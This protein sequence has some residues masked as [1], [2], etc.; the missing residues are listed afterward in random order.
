MN[1]IASLR[2]SLGSARSIHS[3]R[4]SDRT[5]HRPP[6]HPHRL[7]DALEPRTLLYTPS[8]IINTAED[9]FA[10]LI[11]TI[12]AQNGGEVAGFGRTVVNVGDINADGAD[13]LA[14][15]APGGGSAVGLVQL[16]SGK[17]GTLLWT[18]AGSDIG[19]GRAIT[20]I[21]DATSDGV[22]DIAIGS[23]L[24]AVAGAVFIYNG[25]TGAL[26]STILGSTF[27]AISGA[28]FGWSLAAGLFNPDQTQ[29]LAIGAPT[30][31]AIGEG[32]VYIVDGTDPATAFTYAGSRESELFGWSVEFIEEPAPGP[33]FLA[34]GG[35]GWPVANHQLVNLGRISIVNYSGEYKFWVGAANNEM[36]GISLASLPPTE[37]GVRRLAV[38]SPGGNVWLDGELSARRNT[39]IVSIY[40]IDASLAGPRAYITSA[41]TGSR[42]GYSL[43]AGASRIII[44]APGAADN[45]KVYVHNIPA[46]GD[47]YA[48]YVDSTLVRTIRAND[49][50]NF[51]VALAAGEFNLDGFLDVAISSGLSITSIATDP[52]ENSSGRVS[53]FTSVEFS[54]ATGS[55]CLS[56]D[57]SYQVVHPG[58]S[59]SSFLAH[60]GTLTKIDDNF[61]TAGGTFIAIDNTGR[62]LIS[63][64]G[65]AWLFSAGTLTNLSAA[66]TTYVG[67]PDGWA[68]DSVMT[69]RAI[70]ADGSVLVERLRNNSGTTNQLVNRTIW[71]LDAT[72]ATYLWQGEYLAHSAY[73]ALGRRLDSY[74]ADT[75]DRTWTTMLYRVGAGIEEIASIQNAAAITDDGVI[76]GVD[77][78]TNSFV[79]RTTDATLTTLFAVLDA[80]YADTLWPKA[81]DSDGRLLWFQAEDKS[82]YAGEH[83]YWTI[84]TLQIFDPESGTSSDAADGAIPTYRTTFGAST[85]STTVSFT[86]SHGFVVSNPDPYNPVGVHY[87]KAGFDSRLTTPA[88]GAT[89][90]TASGS[91]WTATAFV[92]QL[93]RITLAIDEGDGQWKLRYAA[94]SD[95]FF[96]GDSALIGW[97]DPLTNRP[98]FAG[99]STRF[100]VVHIA[101]FPEVDGLT[102]RKP[103]WLW[104]TR[105]AQLTD[106]DGNSID[107]YSYP[108]FTNNMVVLAR[109][110]NLN[111]LAVQNDFGELYL[112]GQVQNTIHNPFS[113]T[114]LYNLTHELS[115]R[116]N[117]APHFQGAIS[118]FVSPWG[119]H[120]I[121]GVDADGHVWTLWTSPEFVGWQSTDL[122]AWIGAE[123]F[124]GNVTSFI[125]TWNAFNMTGL[126]N[127]GRLTTLWWAPELGP[128]NWEVSFIGEGQTAWDTGVAID[129]WFNQPTQSLNFVGTNESGRVT[130][131]T[132]S[133]SNQTWRAE[134]P[135]NDVTAQPVHRF[136][137]DRYSQ[138]SSRLVGINDADHVIWAYRDPNA[139]ISYDLLMLLE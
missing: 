100:A 7:I 63:R 69:P 45:G 3:L 24:H 61:V 105:P 128:G 79:K 120:N 106:S 14:I 42:F 41:E 80:D 139:W 40:E 13:D 82:K 70:L 130:V 74:N 29:D 49:T 31:G 114:Y 66:I 32:R 101:S 85:I 15:G 102:T 39:G 25:A 62:V 97:V 104:E 71:R 112:I 108:E 78:A 28:R 94:Y 87:F 118:A 36:L 126:D 19:F 23:P 129:S 110:D 107:S 83:W 35:P 119:S 73:G 56:P 135:E 26:V 21:T 111:I 27:N 12:E 138:K 121:T 52:T 89:P 113:F 95:D 122:T 92:N 72:T 18:A 4:N 50:T 81:L 133:V 137:P 67:T 33:Q 34:I 93:G 117:P 84:G 65:A 60:R 37:A 131:Y 43:D 124:A 77:Y 46:P 38:G 91:T 17:T 88:P 53:L 76:V 1:S 75:N 59:D 68:F 99:V 44:G 116:H 96:S 64:S 20:A 16:F 90:A 47:P 2:R 109:P 8:T 103:Y 54:D 10:Y 127:S 22:A 11:S 5:P 132:W 48:I 98:Q 6:H 58:N 125:T 123:P 134:Y 86:N 30:D 136:A 51:G 115:I 55:L 57:A 9:A